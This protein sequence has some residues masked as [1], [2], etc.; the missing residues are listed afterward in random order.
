[1]ARGNGRM[2]IFNDERDYRSFVALM[3]DVLQE[4]AIDCLNYCLMPNHYHCTLQPTLPNLSEAIQ[5]VNGVYAQRWNKRHDHV[6]HV[7][8][9]RFK[10][11]IVQ[12]EGYLLYLCRYVARNPVRAKLV[13]VPEEWEWSSYAATI[14]LRPA[15][16]F[17]NVASTLSQFDPG[18]ER[19]L[20]ARFQSFVSGD[21]DEVMEERFRANERIVGD[22]EFKTSFRPL[23]VHG[24]MAGGTLAARG[25]DAVMEA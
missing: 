22:L 4:Y 23:T 14:G 8:Q 19:A 3:G 6:G 21:P 15:P 1:M 5:H 25:E 2:T 9:G 7:F 20:Q 13:E 12:R 18:D 11:Q 24:P 10:D 17:L 16:A